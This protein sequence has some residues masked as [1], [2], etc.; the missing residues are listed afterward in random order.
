M[1]VVCS[2]ISPHS[3]VDLKN[4]SGSYDATLRQRLAVL[5]A[6]E[7]FRDAYEFV[8]DMGKGTFSHVYKVIAKGSNNVFAMKII[9]CA[10]D[11]ET[12]VAVKEAEQMRGLQHPYIVNLIDYIVDNHDVCLVLDLCEDGDL[13]SL[14][15]DIEPLVAPEE[16]IKVWLYQV[17][18]A[19]DF[20]H[21][22]NIIHR[23]IKLANSTPPPPPLTPLSL[24]LQGQ[25]NRKGRRLRPQPAARRGRHGDDHHG[26][27]VQHGAGDLLR[28]ALQR[29]VPPLL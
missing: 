22:Q 14:T 11:E 13:A 5:N 3:V 10:T 6:R 9:A 24:P 27:A 18:Q 25:N 23:D 26:H 12:A 2:R 16:C 19:L 20:L 7:C 28:A 17:L 1:G 4:A 15:Q 8:A 29:Q 21:G